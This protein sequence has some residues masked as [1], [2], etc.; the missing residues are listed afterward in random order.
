[1][2]KK[3]KQIDIK[4]EAKARHDSMLR[5]MTY[6]QE[7]EKIDNAVHVPEARITQS[8]LYHNTNLQ[9]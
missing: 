1:M 5:R 2:I 3:Q 4:A 8:N 9:Y 7:E 6:A